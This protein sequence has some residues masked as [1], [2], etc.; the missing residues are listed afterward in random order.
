M[1]THMGV[2]VVIHTGVGV[3]IHTAA[4]V[5]LVIMLVIHSTVVMLQVSHMELERALV[6]STVEEGQ[7]VVTPLLV[8]LA[9][10]VGVTR[11]SSSRV[12]EVGG[13]RAL[14]LS[15]TP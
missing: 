6:F 7:E 8:V 14:L 9:A 12:V 2:G 15:S 10:V 11:S 13:S 3:V 4:E 5:V 1:V